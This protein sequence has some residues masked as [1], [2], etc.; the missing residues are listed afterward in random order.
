MHWPKFST[1]RDAFDIEEKDVGLSHGKPTYF[2]PSRKASSGADSEGTPFHDLTAYM[3]I[4]MKPVLLLSHRR[5]GNGM[6]D[7]QALSG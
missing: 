4:P 1:G 3:Y 5:A 6:V 7:C 2:P